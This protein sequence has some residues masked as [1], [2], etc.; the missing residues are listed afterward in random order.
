MNLWTPEAVPPVPNPENIYDM[1]ACS[2]AVIDE[3][4]PQEAADKAFEFATVLGIALAELPSEQRI[5]T[6]VSRQIIVRSPEKP[7]KHLFVHDSGVIGSVIDFNVLTGLADEPQITLKIDVES[8]FKPSSPTDTDLLLTTA[9]LPISQVN[10]I[11]HHLA[12]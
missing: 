2:Q 7:D 6:A 5:L 10:Y 8:M 9:N 11:E 1:A 4:P 12:A 3:T